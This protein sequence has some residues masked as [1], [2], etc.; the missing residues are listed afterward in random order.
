[1]ID[2]QT[3][4]RS[5]DPTLIITSYGSGI[6]GWMLQYGIALVVALHLRY[7]PVSHLIMGVILASDG[8]KMSI[9]NSNLPV[10]DNHLT[11]WNRDRNE[12]QKHLFEHV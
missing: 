3:I 1:L 7:T 10:W 6:G 4:E 11:K 9:Q 8:V 5:L 12:K 2:V